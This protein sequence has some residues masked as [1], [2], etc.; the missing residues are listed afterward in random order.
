MKSKAS[1]SW[2]IVKIVLIIL[3]T[4]FSKG[5]GFFVNFFIF[6]FPIATKIDFSITQYTIGFVILSL[7]IYPIFF[8]LMYSF[9]F[10]KTIIEVHE[11]IDN[12]VYSIN[13]NFQ[14]PNEPD[15]SEDC[16]K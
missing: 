7:I 13:N 16:N 3:K 9:L 2:R 11:M 8:E 1:T 10:K 5:M 6:M 4:L 14:E 12:V 15:G